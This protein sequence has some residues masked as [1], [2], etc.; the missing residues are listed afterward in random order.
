MIAVF[1]P[2]AWLVHAEGSVNLTANG[3][4]RA[5]LDSRNG[6]LGGIPRVNVI[7]VY[8]NPGETINLGSS[9]IGLGVADIFYRSPISATPDN[10]GAAGLIPNR[11]AE[12]AGPGV[13]FAPCAVTVGAGQGGVWEIGFLSP[14]PTN[15]GFLPTPTLAAADWTRDDSD[16]F[17]AAWD[18]TVTDSGGAR[19]PGRVFANYLT[20]HLGTLNQVFTAETFI[21]TF[22]GYRYRVGMNGLDPIAFTYFAN[23]KGFTDGSGDAIYRSLQ[24]TYTTG[25]NF[26]I[27]P[28]GFTFHNPSTPDNPGTNDITHKIFFNQPAGDLPPSAPVPGGG[29]PTWLL[30]SPTLPPPP[31]Q[32]NFT[33][34]EGTPGQAGTAPLSGTFTFSSSVRGSYS[35]VI[36]T[37]GNDIFGDN[38]DRVLV[39]P[40]E[41]GFNP[42]F[43]DGLDSAGTPVPPGPVAYNSQLTVS[44][45]ETHFPFFDPEN[46]PNGLIIERL[47]TPTGSINPPNPYRV[48]YDDRYNFTGGA[49]DFSIC[50]AGQVPP[51][52]FGLGCYGAPPVPRSALTGTLSVAG[53]H[54]WPFNAVVAATY[55]N[56]RGID[57]WTLFPSN[58]ITLPGG[59]LLAQADLQIHKSHV[60]EPASA[61]GLITYTILVTNAG[62]SHVTGATV[63]DIFPGSIG[64][65]TWTCDVISGT[66]DC[67]DDNGSGNISTTIDLNEWGVAVYEVVGTIGAGEIG[68]ITNTARIT[69][70]PDVTDLFPENNVFTDVATLLPQVDLAIEKT[71][72]PKPLVAGQ[73]I[74]YTIV[75]TNFGPS[76]VNNITVTDNLPPQILPPITYTPSTGVYTPGTGAWT[77][78]N[79]ADG[80]TIF[81]TIVGTVSPGTTSLVNTAVVTTPDAEDINPPNDRDPDFNGATP[82]MD[83]AIEKTSQPRPFVPGQPITYTIVVTNFGPDT[84]STLTVTDNLPPEIL[85]PITYIPST[86]VY[87]PGTGAWTGLSLA[88]LNSVTLTIVGRADPNASQLTNTAVVTTHDCE[89]P[90]NRFNDDD[91]YK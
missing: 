39:G 74:T 73:P 87:T 24:F 68:P 7:K 67:G 16:S 48:F 22:D 45:G 26:G 33:G 20:L 12:V 21:Q 35:I 3:G 41:L 83:L 59:I 69:R 18:V 4:S 43:W 76:S 28:P 55:G 75:V 82:Q 65:I 14:D 11:A 17:I 91:E 71:S 86:G 90:E 78:L 79:L 44:A 85:P 10:C 30:V 66:G 46:N 81:L 53:A 56:L 49:Y 38:N 19:I 23:N 42:V 70:T 61:G 31:T 52:P 58:P 37:D 34:N 6:L 72:Q 64:G 27:V 2:F 5:Y 84:A 89:E 47:I 54:G 80:D 1:S 63:G 15:T 25:E 51:P 36:D 13:G 62:P 32:F 88:A 57:T 8:V 9:A 40:A 29:P 60:P 50:A 77:G